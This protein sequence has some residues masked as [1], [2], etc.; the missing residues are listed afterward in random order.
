MR[1]SI[2]RTIKT[3]LVCASFLT[4]TTGTMAFAGLSHYVPGALGLKNATPPP[5]GVWYAGY[6][7]YYT[8]DT[9][10]NDS[11]NTSAIT[12]MDIDVFANVNQ[13]A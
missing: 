4:V 3:C 7:Q 1:S 13:F 9:Y 11:G 6:N 2:G 12:E 8:A 10:K 5:P